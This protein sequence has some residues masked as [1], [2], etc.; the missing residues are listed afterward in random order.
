M[1]IPTKL[2]PQVIALTE[3]L[4]NTLDTVTDLLNN[5][6]NQDLLDL[7][8]TQLS[9]VSHP[10]EQLSHHIGAD[11]PDILNIYEKLDTFTSILSKTID[12]IKS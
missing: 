4:D 10:L 5:P 11:T 12:V 7:A 9:L 8:E 2:L 1:T 6:E 3:L